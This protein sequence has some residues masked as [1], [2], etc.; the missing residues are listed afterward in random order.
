MINEPKVVI[1]YLANY[2]IEVTGTIDET[3]SNPKNLTDET[4]VGGKKGFH[5]NGGYYDPY[6]EED[7]GTLMNGTYTLYDANNMYNGLVG[8]IMSNEHYGFDI[9]QFL[10]I[11]TTQ[12]NTYIK[13]L[14]IYFDTT[15]KEI[16]T[17]LAFSNEP[18]RVYSNNKYVYM[19][20]F[21][22]DSTL[23]SVTVDFLEWSKRN[24]A[25]KVVKIKT[26][27]TATYDPFSI[28]DIYYSRDKFSDVD[29][30]KFGVTVQEA[31][32][33]INDY[34]GMIQEL[35]NSDLIFKNVQVQLYVDGSLEGTYIIDAKNS[36]NTISYWT[37]DCKDLP[38]VRLS[39][40]LPPINIALDEN[41]KPIPKPLKYFIDYALAGAVN[42]IYEDAELEEELNEI[43]IKVPYIAG[44][45]TREEVLTMCC[46]IALLRMYSDEQ[47]NLLVTRGV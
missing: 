2:E 5:L 16:A 29:N 33:E 25:V 34:D 11:T 9:P 22:E 7:V 20:S 19:H 47:G 28:R 42:V 15:A 30:L 41:G 4:P 31:T 6:T 17:K 1:K 38:S 3:I 14:F 45:K 37:F 13:S 43:I 21:G 8:T 12:P 23:T 35:Y 36:D 46:Q 24:A 27:Y 26:G 44:G 39:D 40:T 18:G 10:T 32:F